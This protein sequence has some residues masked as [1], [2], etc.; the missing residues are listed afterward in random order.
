MSDLGRDCAQAACARRL[1]VVY[2]VVLCLLLAAVSLVVSPVTDG[3]D[4]EI[5][6]VADA[7]EP[8]PP[9]QDALADALEALQQ[10]ENLGELEVEGRICTE[11]DP[12]ANRL[13]RRE[14]RGQGPLLEAI[15]AAIDPDQA[16]GV[17]E[18]LHPASHPLVQSVATV[19]VS[20]IL[21]SAGRVED[22]RAWLARTPDLTEEAPCFAAD[23]SYLAGR[24]AAR[25][26]Q[27]PEARAHYAAAVDLNTLHI[28]AHLERVRLGLSAAQFDDRVL[29]AVA[30]L[31]VL[32]RVSG[33]RPFAADLVLGIER[34]ACRHEGCFYLHTALLS[35]TGQTVAAR[36]TLDQLDHF[37]TGPCNGSV[38]RAAATVRTRLADNVESE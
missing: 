16:I 30:S 14:T 34:V 4:T 10:P 9:E 15:F 5:E 20:T 21:L 28:P 12:D 27:M 35:W 11:L 23:A 32:S 19:Q 37:C 26:G 38:L 3:G 36:A 29:D 33:A 1:F 22:A 6:A 24:I 18:R 2:G 17:A 8:P 31:T 25:S 7:S 13:L